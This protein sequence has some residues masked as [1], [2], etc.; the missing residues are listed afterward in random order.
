M[1]I[2]SLFLIIIF[3][4]LTIAAQ[5]DVVASE[6][7][8]KS[9][10]ETVPC[11]SKLRLAKVRELFVQSGASENDLSIE[12]FKEGENLVVRKKGKSEETVFIGAHYDK[13]SD[14]CGA[15]D[16]WTGIVI[17]ANLYRTLSRV[18]T[19]KSYVF[20]AFDKEES[21]LFGSKALVK[22]LPKEK[23]EQYCSMVNLDSFGLAI[24]QAT[25]NLSNSKMIKLA[26]D[27]SKEI[28]IP[29]AEATIQN[30]DTD[31]SSFLAKKI[32]AIAFHGLNDD[33]T[34][35]LHTKQDTKE[36]INVRSVYLG[37]RFVLA[38]LTKID[39]GGCH[40]FKKN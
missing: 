16:N 32:P 1:K 26:K 35:Y 34:K 29:F 39:G 20:V 7:K 4:C 22:T 37:Y 18:S 31:S 14:G 25:T 17:L 10:T 21:G 24:P 15:I 6:E 27:L 33:W 5:S 30:V 13:S 12:K 11:D 23:F 8:I 28:N 19:E 40:I 38:Y 9:E 36:N 3:N 2:I